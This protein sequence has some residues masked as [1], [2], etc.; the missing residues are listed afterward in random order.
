M[1]NN[2]LHV[3]KSVCTDK[4]ENCCLCY[5]NRLSGQYKLNHTT[6]I[7]AGWL[8]YFLSIP[9]QGV[10]L[11]KLCTVTLSL[12]SHCYQL[13]PTVYKHTF[14]DLVQGEGDEKSHHPY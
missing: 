6:V 8:K 5:L 11:I 3:C 9:A 4:A 1:S 2:I 13:A 10:W 12:T 7:L 14:L